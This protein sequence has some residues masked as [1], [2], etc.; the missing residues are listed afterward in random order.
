MARK[1]FDVARFRTFYVSRRYDSS[2][3]LVQTTPKDL[4]N[5]LG[6]MKKGYYEAPIELT[7]MSGKIKQE[8]IS[9]KKL[10][11][12][13]SSSYGKLTPAGKK[14]AIQYLNMKFKK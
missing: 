9:L 1:K 10:K 6:S 7:F 4:I 2:K 12:Y 3:Y 8:K 11:D 13:A 5:V 14:F